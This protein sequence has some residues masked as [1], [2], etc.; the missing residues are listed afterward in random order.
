MSGQRYKNARLVLEDEIVEGALS[1]G[2]GLITE[3]EAGGHGAGEDFDGDYLIP[4]LIE[5]HTDHLETHY[6]PRP[7]VRW[8]MMTA[9]QAHDAQI[10]TS[11][12]TTVFDCFRIGAPDGGSDDDFAESE[13]TELARL[14]REAQINGRLRA[15]HRIHLRCEVSTETTVEEFERFRAVNPIR[16]VSL[17]DHAPGQRQFKTLEAYAVYYKEKK[18]LTDEQF[19]KLVRVRTWQSETYAAPN[20]KALSDLC[21]QNGISIASHDD[22]TPGHVDEAIEQGVRI[23]E[24]PTSMEAARASHENG[25]RVL[26]GA[27]NV[28]RGGS[29]SGNI[30]AHDL[31]EH[32]YLDILSSDYVPMSLIYAPFVLAERLESVS[33]PKAL[34]LVTSEP[35]K[36]A[37]LNDRGSLKE[38]LR[39]D[40]IRVRLED[41]VPVV[42]A[43][44]REGQR[45]A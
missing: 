22:A 26:M 30:A 44:W 40:F 33:L 34:S 42:R 17:M 7:K 3:V 20:R 31:A 9:I 6:A 27:P 16:L 32:G 28:V 4:G 13:M 25:L 24:F 19:D 35:A 11:G 12:I 14:M 41:G 21:R 45:V 8:H 5:L 37:E 23:A 38:G 36:A 1:V 15:D 2:N 10:A 29:H 39:A 18:G 43:V